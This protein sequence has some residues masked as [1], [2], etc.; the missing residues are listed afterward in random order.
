MQQDVNQVQCPPHLIIIHVQSTNNKLLPLNESKKKPPFR[1]VK[2]KHL[3]Y[4]NKIANSNNL[5]EC[6]LMIND[7]RVGPV[8]MFE[9]QP[10]Q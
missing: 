9:V 3:H 2:Q 1:L 6:L 10:A 7:Q 5:Q 8:G 4:V